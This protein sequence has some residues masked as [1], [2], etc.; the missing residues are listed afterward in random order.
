MGYRVFRDKVGTE[1]QAW[2]VVPKIAERRGNERRAR[3]LGPV[4]HERRGQWDRRVVEGE[5]PAVNTVLHG[6]WLC[7]EA[8]E[9]KR[10][11]TPIPGDWQRCAQSRLEEYCAE[12]VPA[13][14]SSLDPPVM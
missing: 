12:A 9:E 14:R 7:F 11:L 13:R 8:T 4:Q 5:R 6:G 10:R 1:W 3:A 2:D